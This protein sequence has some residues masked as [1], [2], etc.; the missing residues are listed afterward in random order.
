MSDQVDYNN[1]GN[2]HNLNNL[3]ELTP[4]QLNEFFRRLQQQNNNNSGTTASITT[5]TPQAFTNTVQ[6]TQT[7]EQFGLFQSLPLQPLISQVNRTSTT[8][9]VPQDLQASFQQISQVNNNNNNNNNTN[10]NMGTVT[11]RLPSGMRMPGSTNSVFGRGLTERQQFLIF[12]KILLK[13]ID[14]TNNPQLRI[15]A[16]AVVAECTQRNRMGDTDYMPLQDAVERRLRVSL[17]EV[18]WARAK[19]CFDTY[20]ARQQ[21]RT[22]NAASISAV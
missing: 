2:V 9:T 21:I 10:F 19:L 1:N 16:K 22:V 13:Y 14:R 6:P 8:T 12:V 4:Q 18:H 15:R 11:A 3:G 20:V 7:G 5:N 17:G